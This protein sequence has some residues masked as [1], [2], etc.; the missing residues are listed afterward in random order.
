MGRWRPIHRYTRTCFSIR[1]CAATAW[2][3]SAQ[4]T[5]LYRPFKGRRINRHGL[6][7]LPRHSQ[8]PHRSK[9]CSRLLV[10]AQIVLGAFPFW[11]L[12]FVSADCACPHAVDA[13]YDRHCDHLP[14]GVWFEHIRPH[15]TLNRIQTPRKVW[16]QEIAHPAHKSDIIR[17]HA[18]KAMGGIYLDLDSYV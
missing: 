6:C 18:V 7:N 5:A 2:G 16:D 4:H 14:T 12:C 17:I 3:Q 8:C 9:T 1:P 15:L 11:C 13:D 10:S